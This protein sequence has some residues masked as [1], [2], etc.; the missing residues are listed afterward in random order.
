MKRIVLVAL[1]AFAIMAIPAQAG[2]RA[3]CTV[4]PD[5]VSIS[6]QTPYTITATGGTPL[7]FYEV[8]IRQIQDGATDERRD[9]LVQA[10]AS[11]L[12]QTSFIAG[13]LVAGVPG[14]LLVE[15]AK[16]NV[17][18]YRTGG[19]P[20]GAASTLATCSFTVIA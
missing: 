7:E 8:I 3:P 16:V 11:G 9:A 1:V 20:G 6:A 18:R 17:V 13:P 10:D 2:K 5:P 19:G 14:G 15:G 12:V 4:V